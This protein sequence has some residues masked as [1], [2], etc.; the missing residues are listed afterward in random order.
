MASSNVEIQ[1]SP[2]SVPSMPSWLG[3][4]TIVAHY[5][6]HVGLLEKIAEHVRFARA[7]FGTYDV[8]DFVVVLIGY[9]LSG[10]PTLKTFYERLLPFATPFMALFGRNERPSHSALSRFLAA[11][12]QPPLEALRLLF[13]KDLVARPLT[14]VGEQKAGLQDR[15]G[16][17]WKVFDVDGTRQA[18]RQRAL[19]HTK[20]LPPAHR[21]MDLVSAAGY[22]GRKRGEVVRTRTTLL[23]AHTHQWFGTFGNAGNGDYRGELLRAREV[24]T[25]YAAEQNIPLSRII[26]RLDGLYGNAAPL[27]DILTSG[28]AVIVRGKDYGLL[29][30]PEVQARLLQPPEEVSTH[31]E[32]GT[33]RALFDCPDI[34]LTPMG[35]RIRVIVATHP[36]SRTLAPVGVTRD[37]V[38]YELFLTVLP[39]VAFTPADVVGLYLHRGAFETVLSD[40]DKEQDPDRWVSHSACGQECWQIL[41]QWMWNVRLELGHR[42]HP[43]P[44]RITEFAPAQ[45]EPLPAPIPDNTPSVI[46]GPAEW[47]RTARVGIFAGTDFTEQTDGTLRC[48]AGH[49]LYAQERRAEQDGTV[50]MVYAARIADCR[51]C[52][53]REQCLLHGKE[54]KGP[55]RV[56]AVLRPGVRPPPPPCRGEPQPPATHPILWGDWSRCQTRRDFISL[57]RTQTVTITVTPGV[58][59]SEDAPDPLPLTRQQRA[60]WRMSWAQRLARNAAKP[61]RPGV[62]IH[63]FGIPTPFATSVGLAA[64]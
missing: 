47:A 10:E 11:L 15:C 5:L 21:R 28:L 30:L 33:C 9:S 37:G 50:R 12:D 39:Q 51:E 62:Q 64:A 3:E 61:S 27:V 19:P 53:L 55:R 17:L 2:Q 43:T 1:T 18:A 13:Q 56:S 46:Y 59:P 44:M 63:L 4:V 26:F 57:L 31:P 6:T 36:A 7:R 52:P 60:H 14:L 23:Q 40:E 45:E 25:S 58:S 35:P 41:S 29:D 24:I 32:T 16:E 20:E 34:P 22:T 8:I 38:V 42:L 54:T 48:P 49:S